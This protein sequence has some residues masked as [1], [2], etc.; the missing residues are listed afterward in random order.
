MPLVSLTIATHEREV[1]A[2]EAQLGIEGRER[3]RRVAGGSRG[4]TPVPPPDIPSTQHGGS[5][6]DSDEEN[7]DEDEEDEHSPPGGHL[8]ERTESSL[9]GPREM[10]GQ[11]LMEDARSMQ[12]ERIVWLLREERVILFQAEELAVMERLEAELATFNA[13]QY[14]YMLDRGNNMPSYS[15]GE[16]V[17]VWLCWLAA[18]GI[19]YLRMAMLV[20]YRG[21]NI[22][23]YG[24]AKYNLTVT[25][26]RSWREHHTERL[27]KW[28]T[29]QMDFVA[30]VRRAMLSSMDSHRRDSAA[31]FE[32]NTNGK[33]EFERCK[34][35]FKQRLDK[36][37]DTAEMEEENKL[38][39]EVNTV[40]AKQASQAN[41]NSC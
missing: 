28:Q 36:M 17:F 14:F 15:Y 23:S 30:N 10:G 27:R 21:N 29:M 16:Y 22:P 39:G 37:A 24:Y 8:P 13:D 11:Q 1:D 35:L 32:W 12:L 38:L 20:G 3:T 26:G 5:D 4:S 7:E 31:L 34:I 2:L 41:R 18:G 25:D 6:K 9:I 33:R 19:I 40:S